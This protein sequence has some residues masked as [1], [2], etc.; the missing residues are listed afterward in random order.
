MER[1]PWAAKPRCP[2]PG[3]ACAASHARNP[4]SSKQRNARSSANRA[5]RD[6]GRDL[7]PAGQARRWSGHACLGQAVS[8]PSSCY[9]A[10][11][12][13]PNS[14]ISHSTSRT[15]H[16]LDATLPTPTSPEARSQRPESSGAEAALPISSLESRK[17][18]A[19]TS[20]ARLQSFFHLSIIHSLHTRLHFLT[21]FFLLSNPPR[22]PE[23]VPAPPPR[24][25]N[26]SENY[27]CGEQDQIY[28]AHP[29]RGRARRAL[30][31]TYGQW[32]LG[33]SHVGCTQAVTRSEPALSLGQ[34]R[35]PFSPFF[36]FM[37]NEF[38]GG[39]GSG[40]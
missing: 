16:N 1:P 13:T 29:S 19:P 35:G 7:A 40:L 27:A 31:L 8:A 12:P 23:H 4:R 14:S 10:H 5:G 26:G 2:C 28:L 39:G 20:T 36:L 22:L 9:S 24:T 6:A 32:K 3:A 17:E 34:P 21:S 15:A 11:P 30:D 38:V 18:T 37:G 25:C 33:C